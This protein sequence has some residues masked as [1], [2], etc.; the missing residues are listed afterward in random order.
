MFSSYFGLVKAMSLNW[1]SHQARL[2]LSLVDLPMS[3]P[4]KGGIYNEETQIVYLAS[5]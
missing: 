2:G 3:I 5:F 1:I 4:P